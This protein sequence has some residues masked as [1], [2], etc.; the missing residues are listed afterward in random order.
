M[1]KVAVDAIKELRNKTLASLADCRKALEETGGDMQKAVE[2]LRKRGLEIA[3]K[4]QDHLAKEGRVDAYIHTGNKIGVLVEV[5]SETDFVAR[6]SEFSQ[7]TKDIAMQIAALS[8]I[9]I[10]KE[11]VPEEVLKQEKDPE[12]FL[13]NHCLLEQPFIKDQSITVKDY[14]AS[15]LAKFN[16]NIVIRRFQRYKI[17]A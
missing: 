4:R 15:L 13:K 8:P 2:F 1:K 17:G 6:N 3:A 5:D 7:F 14:L 16:E 12:A 9:Y 11:D 10:K